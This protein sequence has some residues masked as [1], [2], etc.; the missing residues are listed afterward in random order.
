M[1]G[2]RLKR[3]FSLHPLALAAPLLVLGLACSSTIVPEPPTAASEPQLRPASTPSSTE[4]AKGPTPTPFV[5]AETTF[6]PTPSATS[7]SPSVNADEARTP[8][9]D[10]EPTSEP[11]PLPRA[12]SAPVPSTTPATRKAEEFDTPTQTSEPETGPHESSGQTI[13]ALLNPDGPKAVNS[14]EFRQ[15][16]PLDGIRPIYE[17]RI[18]DSGSARINDNELV[19]GVKIGEQ[20]RAYPIKVLRFREIVNDELDG[21]P[22]LVTW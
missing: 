1:V 3:R 10:A 17:P 2:V 15:L 20:S 7:A 11:T 6:T 18:I 9:L 22:I 4:L 21:V 8:G 12:T 19:I 16:L 5:V 14:D 13:F